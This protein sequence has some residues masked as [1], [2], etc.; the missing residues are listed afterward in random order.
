MDGPVVENLGAS[1]A[2][3]WAADR[4]RW[5]RWNARRLHMSQNPRTGRR[6]EY[7]GRD[8]DEIKRGRYMERAEAVGGVS[9]NSYRRRGPPKPNDA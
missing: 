1:A 8:G 4:I 6:G 9:L 7:D 3:N 2:A 5:K